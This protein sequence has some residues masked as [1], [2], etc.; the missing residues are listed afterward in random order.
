MLLEQGRPA[1][2]LAAYEASLKQDPKR[3]RTLWSAGRAA[4]ALGDT[5]RVRRY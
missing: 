3:F 2:A 1:D 4:E 5:E